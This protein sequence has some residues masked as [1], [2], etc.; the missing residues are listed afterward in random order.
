M[1]LE[2]FTNVL[3]AL[4]IGLRHRIAEGEFLDIT[5]LY[6][7]GEWRYGLRHLVGAINTSGLPI[8]RW[9][10]EDLVRLWAHIRA[11]PTELT[12]IPTI[13]DHES[14]WGSP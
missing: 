5:S 6:S 7:A 2:E 12:T 1:D 14:P 4:T 9:E 13:A 8:Y 10:M 3:C 11:D